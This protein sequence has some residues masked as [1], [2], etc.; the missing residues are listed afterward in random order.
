MN[1]LVK[2]NEQNGACINSAMAKK[3]DCKEI[4]N[5]V[6]LS[7]ETREGYSISSRMKK[8]WAVQLDMFRKLIDVCSEHNLR[9]WCDGGTLLGAVRHHGFIPWDDDIDV[10]MP[11]P[12]YDRLQELAPKVSKSPISSR[13]QRPT[14]TITVHMPSCAATALP[15]YVQAT[16]SGH[17]IREFSSTYSPS[18]ECLQT[19]SRPWRS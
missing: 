3:G 9:C 16:V 1:V 4:N 5:M 15:P 8:V 2:P 13:Q 10:C 17:F 19:G 12:D 18:R 14:S 7:P 11:R 6:N